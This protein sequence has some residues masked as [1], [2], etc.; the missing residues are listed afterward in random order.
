MP[1][2]AVSSSSVKCKHAVVEHHFDFDLDE[3]L[4]INDGMLVDGHGWAQ[5]T[6][7]A[8]ILQLKCK[9]ANSL[10]RSLLK[11][12]YEEP[13]VN[14]SSPKEKRKQVHIIFLALSFY[15]FD[16]CWWHRERLQ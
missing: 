16:I 7:T 12:T 6:H 11:P 13:S 3:E 2:D 1:K 9:W 4:D 8:H 15:N 14:N 10:P 5:K